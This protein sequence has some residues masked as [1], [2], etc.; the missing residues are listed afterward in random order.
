MDTVEN[1]RRRFEALAPHLDEKSLRLFAASETL[2]LARGGVTPVSTAIGIS[3]STFYRYLALP[4]AAAKGPARA[5]ERNFAV[6]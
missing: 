1:I 3:R 5:S 6:Q 4:D 2:P